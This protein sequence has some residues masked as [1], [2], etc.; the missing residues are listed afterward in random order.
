MSLEENE[1]LKALEEVKKLQTSF[2]AILEETKNLS[3]KNS[4]DDDN[5]EEIDREY[6][7]NDVTQLEQLNTSFLITH[8]FEKGQV[9]KWKKGLRNKR[10]PFKN[11]PAIVV[12]VLNPPV[13]FDSKECCSLHFREPLD[14]VLGIIDNDMDFMTFHYDSRRFEP[15]TTE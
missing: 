8:S 10:F 6:S 13:F 7:D 2:L 3:P 5:E 15:Y 1:L 14:I 9:V 11:Q 12:D 4:N